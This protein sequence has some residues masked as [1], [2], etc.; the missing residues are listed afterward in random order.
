MEIHVISKN[1]KDLN[2]IKNEFQVLKVRLPVTFKYVQLNATNLTWYKSFFNQNERKN[3]PMV[4]LFN[5]DPDNSY[6]LVYHN[7]AVDDVN[8]IN[9]TVSLLTMYTKKQ[10]E[11]FDESTYIQMNQNKRTPVPMNTNN[12]LQPHSTIW[13]T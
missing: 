5:V 4:M 1:L 7:S 12:A 9:N 6:T 10:A 3:L 8:K 13:S 2:F 11:T